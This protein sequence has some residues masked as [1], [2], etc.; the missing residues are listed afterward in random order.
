MEKRNLKFLSWIQSSA[1]MECMKG[2][3]WK[4]MVKK[5]NNLF[6]KKVEEVASKEDLLTKSNEFEKAKNNIFFKY[7]NIIVKIAGEY[8]WF[9][10]NNINK[11]YNV[12]DLFIYKE[13][14]YQIRDIG[15]G[16]QRYRLECLDNWHIDDVGPQVYVKDDI[17]YVLTAKNKLW[18]NSLV[19]YNYKSGKFIKKIYD[20]KDKRFNLRIYIG[21]NNCLFL[22]RENSGKESIFVIEELEIAYENKVLQSYFPIGYYKGII[23]YF[24]N[25]NNIWHSKGFKFSTFTNEIEYASLKNNIL[26]LRNNGLKQVYDFKGK[27]IYSF[28]GNIILNKFVENP[29]D[30]FFIDYTDSGI[31]ELHYFINTSYCINK[32]AIVKRYFVSDNK[33]PLIVAKPLCKING[34]IVVSY[35]GYGLSTNLS[36]TR[37]KPFLD[38]GWIIAFA[39]VRGSGDVDKEWADEARTYK[40]ENAI[41]DL[42]NCIYFLQNKFKITYINTC[43]YGRS[44]GGYLIGATLV[45]NP[46]GKLF[47]IVYAEV[48][49]VDILRTTTNPKLPLTIL[50]YDEFG[51]PAESIFEFEKILELSPVDGLDY[52][53]PPNVN[54]IIRTSENDSQVYTYES[55]KWL[56]ALRG[57]DK[58][59]SR[60]LLYNSQKQ[61]H[62]IN[63]KSQ[64]MNYSED[65]FLLKQFRDVKKE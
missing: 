11:S 10:E 37:W 35:G 14:I 64:Y 47:S 49:Y 63:D 44:A 21:D 48:P 33:I 24:Y 26:I 57:K 2:I 30:R 31:Q 53:N 19:A 3:K 39:C 20:E 18:Y 58:N 25:T 17:C 62:F 36:T 15:N 12:T 59:D 16:S 1:W 61:G 4:N 56:D 22:I 51:N 52:T 27:E 7:K 5:E 23:S 13:L 28:Y 41:E 45:K 8:E 42:E 34:L 43:I 46:E 50:E 38:D 55:Y 54:V 6:M 65:F 9:Y 40:K 32:Y 29:F 60:K